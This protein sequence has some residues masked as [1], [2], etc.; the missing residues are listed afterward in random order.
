MF[1]SLLNSRGIRA[2]DSKAFV[3]MKKMQI[4]CLIGRNSQNG[5][6]LA[7]LSVSELEINSSL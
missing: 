1:I 6:L 5:K 2:A 4:T 3:D 7:W